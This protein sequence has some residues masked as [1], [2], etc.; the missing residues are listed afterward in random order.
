M[1]NPPNPKPNRSPLVVFAPTGI[2]RTLGQRA[3]ADPR[4]DD[5]PTYIF[6]PKGHGIALSPAARPLPRPRQDDAP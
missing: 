3:L 6:D 5:A 2:G 1:S 4:H